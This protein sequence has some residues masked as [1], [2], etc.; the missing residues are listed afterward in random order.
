MKKIINLIIFI[1]WIYNIFASDVLLNNCE[2]LKANGIWLG[3]GS[4]RI[5][6]G[7]E[8]EAITE[9]KNAL[10]LVLKNKNIIKDDIAILSDFKPERFSGYKGLAIDIYIPFSDTEN[11]NEFF[12]I[13]L[14]ADSIEQHKIMQKIAES[15]L[16]TRGKN[17]VYFEFNFGK[18]KE[19]ELSEKDKIDR[20]NFVF[21]VK[22]ED[23]IKE[24]YFD[25]I[26]LISKTPTVTPTP[27]AMP[28]KKI[29]GKRV[30]VYYPY[31]N[32][33][34]RSSK[35]PLNKITNVCHAFILPTTSGEIQVP[36]GYLEP[37]LLDDAHRAGVKVLASIGGYN[38]EAAAAFRR[39]AASEELRK[40]FAQNLEK[41]LRENKY[42]G[43]DFDWEFPEGPQDKKNFVLLLKEVKEYFKKKGGVATYFL[44][45]M[46]V[47]PGHFYAQ[48]LDY[49]GFDKFID[50]YNVMTY[51]FHGSWSD[52]CG[53]NSPL[54]TGKDTFDNSS[55][56][57][58]VDYIV[59]TRLV[60]AEKVNLGIPFFGRKFLTCG[61]INE[62]CPGNCKDEYMQYYTIHSLIGFGWQE[63]WDDAARV[64]YL[65]QSGGK[66]VISYDNAK[67]I[68]EKVKYAL[69]K[70]LGGVFV[71][72]ITGDY[73]NGENIFMDVIYKEM[74]K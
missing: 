38:L 73:V 47:N 12:D 52:H 39:I 13:S 44:I 41:F 7:E 23:N 54:Y 48:W 50:F 19:N 8:K 51:D 25:N 26:R 11:K 46:A 20:I 21:M 16:L 37:E 34:Y 69:E 35:I 53:H 6:T 59:N 45:T 22:K 61:D 68:K 72:D 1:I 28:D 24:I 17:R 4:E 63:K 62:K 30:L 57:A 66:N 65:I 58:A 29:A 42:D 33:Q 3:D 74:K 70:N 15:A 36:A 56:D 9:G 18:N 60:K 2:N 10:K 40:I 27:T 5:I 43:I 49:E 31:W 55:C 71:W 32:P 64:P 14:L 67:S